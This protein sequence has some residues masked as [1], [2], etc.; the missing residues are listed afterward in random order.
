LFELVTAR[1][2]W[3][4]ASLSEVLVQIASDPTPPLQEIEPS[5]PAPFAAIVTRCLEKHPARRYQHVADLAAAL[6][7]YGSE[8]AKATFERVLRIAG[9]VGGATQT[10]PRGARGPA[11]E[12]GVST[13]LDSALDS[14]PERPGR[15]AARVVAMI[16]AV[17]AI[18]AVAGSM[19]LVRR[20]TQIEP[21][22]EVSAASIAT[23][24]RGPEPAIQVV[25]VE[26]ARA[27]TPGTPAVSA[28]ATAAKVAV[29]VSN[30]APA[31]APRRKAEPASARSPAAREAPPAPPPVDP[32][33]LRR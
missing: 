7:P 6:L 28:P 4:G 10:A 22:T 29:A 2:V 8:R 15:R 24:A 30:Q 20:S 3:T 23:A 25:P 5:V 21:A 26:P 27:P 16:A 13:A 1:V 31:R 33:S 18:A 11:A 32:M 14:R 12:R 9:E 17:V 19:L